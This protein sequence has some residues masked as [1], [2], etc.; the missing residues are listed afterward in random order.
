[1]PQLSPAPT[2]AE[3]IRTAHYLAGTLIF[4]TTVTVALLANRKPVT[5]QAAEA[6][7]PSQLEGA[8]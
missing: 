5:A 6:L 1:L 7:R 4:A 3:W 8:L 2:H